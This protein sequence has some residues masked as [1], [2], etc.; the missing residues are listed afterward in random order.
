MAWEHALLGDVSPEQIGQRLPAAGHS[1]QLSET[2]YTRT[3]N[4]QALTTPPTKLHLRGAVLP[5]LGLRGVASESL[6]ERHIEVISAAVDDLPEAEFPRKMINLVSSE[7]VPGTR[8]KLASFP[9][10][11]AA[12]R[13]TSTGNAPRPGRREPPVIAAS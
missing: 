8:T 12:A 13:Q 3:R 1:R 2:G 5:G 6:P 11:L 4:S 7:P 10:Q 9:G